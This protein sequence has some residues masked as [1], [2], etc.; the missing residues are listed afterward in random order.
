MARRISTSA[1][2][3]GARTVFWIN[4]GRG[5]FRLLPRLAQRNSSTFSMGVDFADVNRD[6]QDD[7]FVVD[8]L[9][10]DH[11]RRMRQRAMR[12]HRTST[13]STASRTARRLNAI[14]S[15]LIAVTAPTPRSPNS[16]DCTRANGR[17]GVVF[18]DVDLDGFEDA[19][20]TTGHVFDTQDADTEARIAAGAGG[21]GTAAEKLLPQ[22]APACAQRGVPQSRR[23]ELRGGR[24]RAGASTPS[25]FRTECAWPT[26]I[27]TGIST[28]S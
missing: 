28:W 5:R 13:P 9:S 16:R 7:F 17:G 24:E 23:V 14:R 22:P 26:S 6:G 18:V 8:M 3:S 21:R 25:G 12:G 20:I 19:L 1:T 11:A 15:S 27:M 10:R 4:D 2:I